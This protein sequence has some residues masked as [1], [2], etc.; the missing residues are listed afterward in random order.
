MKYPNLS[1]TSSFLISTGIIA[2]W[3]IVNF[4]LFYPARNGLGDLF[5]VALMFMFT[6]YTMLLA[7]VL[8]LLLRLFKIIQSGRNFWVIFGLEINLLT[9]IFSILLFFLHKADLS[10]L[11]R[12]LLNLFI[13][14]LLLADY[15]L[16]GTSKSIS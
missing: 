15:L 3:V 12:S 14:V 10:W 13:G 2:F 8:I 6:E 9:G 11:N 1:P 4:V 5:T 16:Y 7:G